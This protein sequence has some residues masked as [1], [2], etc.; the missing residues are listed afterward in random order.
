MDIIQPHDDC[1]HP[2]VD[3]LITKPYLYFYY[4]DVE[5]IENNGIPVIRFVEGNQQ[6]FK[7]TILDQFSVLVRQHKG[8]FDNICDKHNFILFYFQRLPFI[9]VLYSPFENLHL[10]RVNL[11]KISHNIEYSLYRVDLRRNKF[12]RFNN[13]QDFLNFLKNK[14]SDIMDSYKT[15]KHPLF[16]DSY[17]AVLKIIDSIDHLPYSSVLRIW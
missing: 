3:F 14:Y 1:Y 13:F 8:I 11:N 10:F 5:Y 17:L 6:K 15:S 12:K 2:N 16:V 9:K 4:D 7:D